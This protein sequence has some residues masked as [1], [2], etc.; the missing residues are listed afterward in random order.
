MAVLQLI[1]S[2][3]LII[4]VKVQQRAV[5]PVPQGHVVDAGSLGVQT[6]YDLR[7]VRGR[8]PQVP[9][10]HQIQHTLFAAR[11]KVIRAGNE[12]CAA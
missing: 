3:R 1:G 10:V 5:G 2:N 4:R 6:L 11:D 7:V 9:A 12:Y 8:V